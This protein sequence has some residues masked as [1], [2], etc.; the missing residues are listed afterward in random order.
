MK[1]TFFIVLFL[2]SQNLWAKDEKKI[3]STSK[4]EQSKWEHRGRLLVGYFGIIE[5]NETPF[6]QKIYYINLNYRSNVT[7]N[8]EA[9]VISEPLFNY[10]IGINYILP[11]GKIGFET[12]IEKI[13]FVDVHAGLSLSPLAFIPLPFWGTSGGITI[14]HKFISGKRLGIDVEVGANTIIGYFS[15]YVA[16]AA[17]GIVFH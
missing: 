11:Y 10:E 17:V 3:D 4:Q 15:P 8:N 7:Q 9:S 5:K 2:C 13:L 14:T 1:L 16:Y 6:R 12:R